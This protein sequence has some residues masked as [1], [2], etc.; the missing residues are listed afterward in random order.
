MSCHDIGNGMNYVAKL[1]SEMY[2]TKEISKKTA[3]KI[4]C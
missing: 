1:I 4:V 2:D 3:V